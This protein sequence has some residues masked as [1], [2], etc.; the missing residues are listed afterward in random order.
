M[1]PTEDQRGRRGVAARLGAAIAATLLGAS[2]IA[3][4]AGSGEPVQ[5]SSPQ[6]GSAGSSGSGEPGGTTGEGTSAEG[7]ELSSVVAAHLHEP[8]AMVPRPGDDDHVWVAERAGRVQRLALVDGGRTLEAEGDDV[9]LDITDDTTTD[10]ER[11]LLDLAFSADG[12]ELFTS[13]TDADGNTRIASYDIG[14]T[15]ADPVIDLESE[16]VRFAVPQPYANHNGGHI[17][18]GP[19]GK[20]WLGLG[21]GGLAD[22]PENRAQDPSTPLGKVVR[23]DVAGTAGEV[24]P[25]IVVTGVRNPWRWAFDTDG[26]LWIADV[27]QNAIEEIDHLPAEEIE[28]ANLGWSGYEGSEPYLDGDG[29]RP[30]DAIAPV[31]EYRHEGGNCSI[32]GGFVYRGAEIPALVGAFLFA[33]YCAGHVRAIRLDDDGALAQEYDLGIDVANPVSFGTDAAGEAYVLSQG[34]DVVRLTAAG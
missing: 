32:T 17:A 25:E 16:Q 20:L 21:D 6:V 33:D 8:V 23:L 13:S 1:A 2:A 22:D 14:G 26:S 18:F 29:R 5:P 3:G 10:A 24:E 11:G 9:L 19:D 30:D 27:G 7:P 34:G 15:L 31:F 12:D 4:C 28:G